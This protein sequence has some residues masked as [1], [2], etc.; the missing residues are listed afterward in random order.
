[1]Y[2]EIGWKVEAVRDGTNTLLYFEWAIKMWPELLV[3][4]FENGYLTRGLELQVNP[5][6]NRELTL[7]MFE[8]SKFLHPFLCLK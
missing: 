4:P 2:S 3:L 6:S 7:N 5:I 1:M 8:I